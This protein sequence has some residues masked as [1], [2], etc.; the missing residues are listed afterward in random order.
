MNAILIVG[1]GSRDP[2]GN[3]QV[4]QFVETLKPQLD[5]ALDY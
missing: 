5:P 2:E 4:R 3:E 1:H